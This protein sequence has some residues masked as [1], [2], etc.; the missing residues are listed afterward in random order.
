MRAHALAY[1]FATRENN[2]CTDRSKQSHNEDAILRAR[3]TTDFVTTMSPSDQIESGLESG[4]LLAGTLV[5][6]IRG[7]RFV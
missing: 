7:H 1:A 6:S 2:A 5:S 4:H 3:I